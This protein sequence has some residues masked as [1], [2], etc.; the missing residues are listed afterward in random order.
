MNSKLLCVLLGTSIAAVALAAAPVPYRPDGHVRHEHIQGEIVLESFFD[1]ACPDCKAANPVVNEV[2]KYYGPKKVKYIL[3][4]F[5]LPYHTY[6]FT[7]HGAA[8]VVEKIGGNESF[9]QYVDVLYDQ[10]SKFSNQATK[11]L[12]FSEVLEIFADLAVQVG[13]D[14]NAFMVGFQNAQVSDYAV[15]GSWKYGCDHSVSGTP[16]FY[17]NGVESPASSEWTFED[18]TKYLDTF[19]ETDD[20]CPGSTAFCDP[21]TGTTYCCKSTEFCVMGV[22]CRC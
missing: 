18:W 4:D 11:E 6:S 21:G 5:P 3:H 14:Y 10:Q 8:R 20:T 12:V 2:V 16:T 7:A 19:F 15:R 17:I 22:G 9:W 13:V 1:F